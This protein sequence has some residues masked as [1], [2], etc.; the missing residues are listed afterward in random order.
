MTATTPSTPPSGSPAGASAAGE[1]TAGERPA[2]ER[3][4][5]EHPAGERPADLTPRQIVTVM[6]GLMTGMLL[7]ALDQTIVATALPTVVGDLGGLEHYSW[8]VTAYLL[9]STASTPLYGKVSDLYGRRPVFQFAIAT[10]LV[11]SL[12]AGLAQ[13][14]TQLIA[15]R[16]IQ[17]LGA[18]GLMTMAFVIISDVVSPRERAK[19]QG[20]FGAVFGLSSVAGPLLGGY[21]AENDWRWMFFINVPLGVLALV[22]TSIVLRLPHVRSEHRI[23]Y[24]GAA[25]L[26][27]GVS[28]LLLA[29]SWGGNEY[30]W[31]SGTIVGLFV[32]GAVL[33][34]LFVLWEL[35][36]VEPILPMRLF[37]DRTFSLANV[38]TFV[39][40]V[41]MFGAIIY[42][43]LYLQIVKGHSPTASGLLLLPLMVGILGSS[44]GGGRVISRVGR[45]KWF[46]VA[47]AVVMTVG[48]LLHTRLERGTPQ[49][50]ASLYML[51][52]GIGLGFVMQPLILAVQNSLTVRD[53]GSGTASATFFR[54]LGGAFGVAILGSVL[55]NR[56]THWLAEL[57]PAG[58]TGAPSVPVGELLG[59]PAAI[60]ALPGPVR[61]AVQEAFV[62]SLHTVFWVAAAV[63]VLSIVV[64][65]LLPDSTLRGP[66]RASVRPDSDDG[67]VAAAEAR[68]PAV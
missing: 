15:T 39:L 20:L 53:M 18:G 38:G 40:G 63:A 62:R 45:Y 56:L 43:P 58:G 31:G 66:G 8:V 19:Y 26:V 34:V 67:E 14:M 44:I 25:L 37:R 27:T 47:G 35:R 24:L 54:T 21:F 23:D 51:V 30:A 17:G 4:V 7:A 28:Q 6:A 52:V 11:G 55:N 65:L 22:V 32:G 1:R 61:D 48:L 46:T 3:P 68:V 16:A 10:F 33:S 64:T 9:T 60:L 12:L 2:Y 57:L 41:A 36:A 29:L 59:R 49:W 50:E 42:I 13:D 5:D